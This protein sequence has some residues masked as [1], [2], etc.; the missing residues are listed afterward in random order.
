MIPV[1][2]TKVLPAPVHS[3]IGRVRRARSTRSAFLLSIALI[4][5]AGASGLLA[6]NSSPPASIGASASCGTPQNEVTAARL[7]GAVDARG[8]PREIAWKSAVPARFCR[9]WQGQHAD[10]GRETQVR[11]IWSPEFLYLRF[12]AKYRNIFTFPD[13]NQRHEELWTRDVA[14]V[15][16]QPAGESGHFYKEIEVSPNGDW[17]DL[18]IVAGKGANLNCSM[19][20][21]MAIRTNEKVWT[22]EVALPMGCLTNTFDPKQNW[23]LNFFRVEGAGDS[24]FSSSW[25]PTNTAKPNFHVPEVFGVLRFAQP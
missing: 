15:F 9:D 19:K 13:Q 20:S 16:L 8:F 4:L 6:Q 2:S 23:R 17:L 18:D 22:A 24:R 14:E 7:K 11:A 12:E 10:A 5:A 3:M 25:H 1:R 21:R